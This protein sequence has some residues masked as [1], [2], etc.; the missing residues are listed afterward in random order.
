MPTWKGIVGRGFRA[1]DF[2]D[3]VSTLHFSDWRPRF[4][5]VHNT[6]VPKLSQWHSV[7]GEARM[8]NLE[9]YYKNEM[10]WSAGPHLF[11]ANDFIWV[12]TSLT[13]SG[14]HSPSWNAE[15]WGVEMVGDYDSEPLDQEVHQNILDALAIL[16]RW[17]GL[18]PDSI[19]FH[20]EDPKTTHKD[21]P[22]R[23]VIKSDLIAQVK[24]RM[25]SSSGEHRLADDYITLGAAAANGAASG[26]SLSS[27]NSAAT[28]E[29]YVTAFTYADNSPPFSD[30]VA[31]SSRKGGGGAPEND[32]RASIGIN[33]FANP[34]T[35]AVGPEAR[36]PYDTRVFI[37]GYGWFVVEDQTAPDLS[38]APRFDLWVAGATPSEAAK[39]TGFKKVTVFPPGSDIP[40]SWRDLKPS[41]TWDCTKWTSSD[42][43]SQLKARAGASWHGL[44][45]NGRLVI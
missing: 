21:C 37:E 13:T 34:S 23:N 19:R 32:S 15:S 8:R 4:V 18:D 45:V 33:D 40:Q 9:N 24:A 25:N 29:R 31:Q 30:Y 3:Y 6:G 12:F 42:R 17:R 5:V 28:S 14:V 39:L 2:D 26:G 43:I 22:G 20:K 41:S 16:H 10:R 35:L 11:V 7:S 36:L 1:P 44:Y 27:G 38:H